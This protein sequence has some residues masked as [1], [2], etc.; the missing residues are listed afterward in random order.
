MSRT[1]DGDDL[2]MDPDIEPE[3]VEELFGGLERQVLLLFDEP[4]DE[5]RQAAVGERDVTG[6]FEHDDV[7]ASVKTAKTSGRRHSS[8]DAPDDHDILRRLC[9]LRTSGQRDNS[10]HTP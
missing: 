6:A 9:R 3:P 4:A 10:T 5:V 7:G 8:R 1:V 2:V